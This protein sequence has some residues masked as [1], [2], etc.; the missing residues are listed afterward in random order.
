[1]TDREYVFVFYAGDGIGRSAVLEKSEITNVSADSRRAYVGMRPQFGVGRSLLMATLFGG[2]AGAAEMVATTTEKPAFE[3]K[4][5]FTI[6][7]SDGGFIELE[8]DWKRE[9]NG[10]IIKQGVA[11]FLRDFKKNR[12]LYAEYV[13]H[14]E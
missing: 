8:F 6:E 3:Q 2:L 12:A 14:T 13:E 1:M 11:T 7:S 9:Y 5:F 4:W 10:G